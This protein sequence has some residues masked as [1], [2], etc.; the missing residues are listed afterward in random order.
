M[1]LILQIIVISCF[2]VVIFAL[3]RE[4]TDFLTYSMGSMLV[5]A[6]ATFFLSPD[7]I[8]MEEFFLAIDWEVIFFLISLFTIVSILEEKLIFQEV[9]RRITMKFHTNTRKF[10]WVIC[11]TSTISAAF[12][13]DVSVAVIFVPMI[14]STSEKMK[15]NPAPILLGMTICINLAA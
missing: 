8:S 15:I 12:I 7:P 13:E 6:A 4:R 14:I 2:I 3:F 1:L 10:F 9:A 11:L 5:A